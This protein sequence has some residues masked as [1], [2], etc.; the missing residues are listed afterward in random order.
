MLHV[1]LFGKERAWTRTILRDSVSAKP[2]LRLNVSV[3]RDALEGQEVDT[4]EAV[5]NHCFT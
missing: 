2:D 3:I 4:L 5:Y 1:G